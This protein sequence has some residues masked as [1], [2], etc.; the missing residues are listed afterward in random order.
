MRR[1]TSGDVS[2]IG[3]TQSGRETYTGSATAAAGGWVGWVR[4]P[5]DH[6]TPEARAAAAHHSNVWATYQARGGRHTTRA[7]GRSRYIA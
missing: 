4:P 5:L 3:L 7:I 2:K 6:C 1:Y